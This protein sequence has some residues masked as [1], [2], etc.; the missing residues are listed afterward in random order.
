MDEKERL[1]GILKKLSL[2]FPLGVRFY[3]G[4]QGMCG[5]GMAQALSTM[6]SPETGIPTVD[7]ALCLEKRWGSVAAAKIRFNDSEEKIQD[8]VKRILS[9]LESKEARDSYVDGGDIPLV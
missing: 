9:K 6:Y 1:L 2:D 7:F 4:H 8:A 5:C 3:H